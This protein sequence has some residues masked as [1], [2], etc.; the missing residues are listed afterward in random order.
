MYFKLAAF[1]DAADG[2]GIVLCHENEKGIYG[3][4]GQKFLLMKLFLKSILMSFAEMR[5][6]QKINTA[7]GENIDVLREWWKVRW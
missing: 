1:A 2:S 3:E 6:T 5:N 4:T 7:H